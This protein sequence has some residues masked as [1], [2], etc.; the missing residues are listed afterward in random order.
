MPAPVGKWADHPRQCHARSSMT[1]RRCRRWALVTSDYCQFHGGRRSVQRGYYQ[2]SSVYSKYLGPKLSA[3]VND[4]LKRPHVEQVQLYEELA[5]AR[6]TAC[7]ALKLAQPLFDERGDKLTSE[8]R[9]LMMQTLNEAMDNVKELVLACSRIEKDSA[10]KVSIKVLNL[11][12][13]QIVLAVH[14]VCGTEHES[15]AEAI[16][17]AIDDKVRLPVLDSN[18]TEIK[19]NVG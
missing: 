12:V 11:V 6:S 7:E 2:L 19:V 14:E 15:L 3:R 13:N 8:T 17:Q 18:A 10:D 1:G 5:I 4:L 9:V 16:A